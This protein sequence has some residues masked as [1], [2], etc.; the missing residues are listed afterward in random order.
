MKSDIDEPLL[1]RLRRYSL[2]Y[3]C[4]FRTVNAVSPSTWSIWKYSL[5]A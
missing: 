1:M 3:S 5:N 4:P 2:E